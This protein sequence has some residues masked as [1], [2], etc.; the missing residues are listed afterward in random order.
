MIYDEIKEKIYEFLCKKADKQYTT[1]QI[2]SS[3]G[4]KGD[5]K[6]KAQSILNELVI[7]QKINK[8]SKRYI[9]NQM[10][11]MPV[12]DRKKTDDIVSKAN[13]K[14]NVFSVIGK[15]DAN[16][17]A[18]NLSYAFV[19]CDKNHDVFV[20]YEDTLNAY[21]NDLV[22]V[23]ISNFRFQKRYGKIIKIIQRNKE[24]FT[25]V[26]I[27]VNNKSYFRADNIKIHTLFEVYDCVVSRKKQNQ[28]LNCQKVSVE[29]V[30]WGIR[31]KNRLP[32]CR[33]TEV[34]GESGNP[35][36]E[37]LSVI[38]D[39]NLPL[40][41]PAEVIDE[42]SKYD[43]NINK[44]DLA[45][46]KDLRELFTIT[47]DP[48]SAKDFDDAISLIKKK[49][50]DH[51]LFVHI[52]DV[53]H[54]I[55]H[56]SNIFNE[57][58]NRGNSYYFPKKVIPM[59]PESLSNKLCSLRP[60]EDK[61][62][63]TVLSVF[64]TEGKIK[65]QEIFESVIRS[66]VRLSY[67][68]VD[69]YLENNDINIPLKLIETLQVMRK[70]SETL[71]M[72]KHQRG[73][74]KF[75]I[76]EIE[77]VYDNEGFVQDICRVKNTESHLMIEN[78]MLIA[79]EYV[80][81]LLTQKAKDTLYRIHEKP[82]IND[83]QNIKEILKAYK[84]RFQIDENLNKTWQNVLACLPDGRFQRVFDR[85]ILRSMKKAKY[86]ISHNQHF[87]LGLQTYTHFTSPIRRFCDLVI[88]TQ[89]KNIIFKNS[90][91]IYTDSELFEYASIATEKEAI[92]DEAERIV[93]Q[94]IL[95]SFMSKNI[96]KTYSAIISGFNHSNIFIELHEA[97]IRG[98]IKLNQLRDDFYVFDNILFQ[99]KGKRRGRLFKLC[100]TV[101]VVLID[102]FGDIIFDIYEN[103]KNK[104]FAKCNSKKRY[105]HDSKK[106]MR[107]ERK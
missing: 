96:G 95:S 13:S 43:G 24:K 103:K 35:E 56:G 16:P 20:S 90:D 45:K 85:L 92:A 102:V 15:F 5:L 33:I 50:G 77:Y 18:K 101:N 47:I 30:N 78:F 88:H 7:D 52:A 12:C 73:Y 10:K 91:K 70:F 11:N 54:F 6:A 76:P 82:D 63:I 41:F 55:R 66:D 32:V 44:H 53:S 68:D 98:I 4:L 94:K 87:G 29:I 39:F 42:A 57:A 27:N 2:F 61:Y 107:K 9:C 69:K 93:E 100:D 38:R 74:L 17:L 23:E 105:N 36:I 22:E 81:K 60:N 84:I 99:V 25:G 86:S 79:N 14:S 64:N 31:Q 37:I 104:T 21:H 28:D 1:N 62:T 65:K 49:N 106:S 71:T 58:K 72:I 46:R 3:L 40:E 19:I 67:D 83:L 48:I 51:E 8:I 26:I 75:N 34:L 89:I 59:L 97:P 80:A